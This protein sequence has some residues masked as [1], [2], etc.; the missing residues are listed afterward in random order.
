MVYKE[1]GYIGYLLRECGGSGLLQ[2]CSAVPRRVVHPVPWR[3]D[4]ILMFP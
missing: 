4:I 3:W 1:A 2:G